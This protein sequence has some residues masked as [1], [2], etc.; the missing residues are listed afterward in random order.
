MH[1]LSNTQPRDMLDV[2][3]A[4]DSNLLIPRPRRTWP[5]A[6][7]LFFLAGIT[8]ETLSG[9]TPPLV[10]L[11][12]PVSFIFNPLLYGCGALLIRE[13]A[14]RRKL[15]WGSILWMGAAY[16]VFE[17]GLVI[18]TW[19]NPWAGPVCHVTHGVATGLCDYSRVAGI[20]L[21]WAFEL[22]V[23][24]AIVSITIP[25]LLVELLFP[26]RA[27][28]TWLGRKGIAVCVAAETLCLSLGILLSFSIFRKHGQA[29]PLL[30][31]YVIEVALLV[32]FVTLALTHPSGVTP[33]SATRRPPRL[34]V[35]RVLAL[36][37]SGLTVFLP[38]AFQGLHAPV[39][40]MLGLGGAFVALATWRVRAWSRRAGWNDRQ[41][42]ALAAGML[43]F[44]LL[45]WDP[46]LEILGQAGGQPTR[47]TAVV[48]LAYLIALIIL[49]RRTA[50]RAQQP[51]DQAT[52]PVLVG[53]QS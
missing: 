45:L 24:H 23:F 26:Q 25:I 38:G 22:T 41:R 48:A 28:R 5:P 7:T 46:L 1:M 39:L 47:G 40:L 14:R 29:G 34:W 17:E 21:A 44:Y 11:T 37:T 53:A 18:N 15:G 42:L 49:A 30:L 50:R 4:A 20:N 27:S 19:A 52:T 16:G 8:A 12:N 32:G 3:L 33:L 31:P 36:L 9:S 2:P 43:G 51:V 13:V 10:F 35:L 6:L